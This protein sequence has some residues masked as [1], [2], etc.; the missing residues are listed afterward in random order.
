MAM[1]LGKVICI[2]GA[3]SGIG[4]QTARLA[5]QQGAS[6]AL[7]DIQKLNLEESV[8]EL[9]SIGAN[10]MGAVVD[11]TSH[12]QVDA[13]IDATIKHFGKLDGAANFAGVE[14]KHEAFTPLT[15]LSDD[16]WERVI[17]VNLTGTMF[18]MRAQLRVMAQGGSIVNVSSTAGLQGKAGLA[19]Y[20]TSK[21]GVIGLSR[22]A[23]KES[24]PK[25]I[26]VNVVAP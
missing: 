24:G 1:L 20:S 5:A 21:H 26:R 4:L 12:A 14:R 2:T 15:D 17:A 22:T 13:W 3:A 9:K 7:C 19:P 6:L 18:C 8:A 11:V 16:E 23:A 25:G 10:V